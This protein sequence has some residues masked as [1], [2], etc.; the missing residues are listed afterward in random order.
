MNNLLHEKCRA[1]SLKVTAKSKFLLVHPK[2]GQL[3]KIPFIVFH[4][5]R[6]I[7]TGQTSHLDITKHSSFLGIAIVVF[8][9]DREVHRTLLLQDYF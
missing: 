4:L 7:F 9:N 5:A 3:V 6:L 2:M 1:M 8:F